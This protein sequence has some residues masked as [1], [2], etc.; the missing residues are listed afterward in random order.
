[1]NTPNVPENYEKRRR[2]QALLW[3]VHSLLWMVNFAMRIGKGMND[4][5]YLVA[6]ALCAVLGFVNAW[7]YFRYH[8]LVNEQGIR[9]CS[10]FTTRSL[11]WA[12][13]TRIELSRG[14]FLTS[15]VVTLHSAEDSNRRLC[16]ALEDDL[17]AVVRRYAPVPIEEEAA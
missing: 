17:E 8:L 16:L 7:S 12:E 9:L 14:G 2:G 15:D 6:A 13:V 1:M 4:A 5:L 11:R 3:L 10:G